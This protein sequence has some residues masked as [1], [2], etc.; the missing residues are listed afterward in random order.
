M[1]I[2][3]GVTVPANLTAKHDIDSVKFGVNY[4]IWSPGPIVARY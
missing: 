2:L 3:N 1:N 4:R